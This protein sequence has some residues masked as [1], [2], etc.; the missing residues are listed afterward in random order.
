[1]YS[2]VDQTKARGIDAMK[3]TYRVR[4]MVESDLIGVARILVSSGICEDEEDVSRRV[5]PLLLEGNQLC[6]V[7]ASDRGG[8]LIGVL[9]A[10]FNG[11]HVFLS[12]LAIHEDHR[13]V[14]IG[15][16]LH[17]VLLAHAVRL[18][19]KGIV[20]DSRLTT[21]GFF[22]S[23]GYQVPGAVFLVNRLQRTVSSQGPPTG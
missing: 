23:L 14:G 8:H 21:T 16:R 3:E 17:E 18:G 20:A 4:S 15:T 12:H 13:R 5:R 11:F 9:V 10:V 22:H 2:S 7:V 6:F 1:M 19:A